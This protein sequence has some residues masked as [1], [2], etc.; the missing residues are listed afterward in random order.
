MNWKSLNIQFLVTLVK[1]IVLVNFVN[2]AFHIR[3]SAHVLVDS[4]LFMKF[5]YLTFKVQSTS[6]M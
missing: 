1:T 2:V 4:S 3:Q 6:L 5:C